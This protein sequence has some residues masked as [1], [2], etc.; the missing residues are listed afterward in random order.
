MAT[1]SGVL[2][3]LS[4]FIAACAIFNLVLAPNALDTISRTPANS[5]TARTDPPAMIPVPALAGFKITRAAP[6]VPIV[7]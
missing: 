4:P 2:I 3:D 5:R 1:S 7:S 6:L